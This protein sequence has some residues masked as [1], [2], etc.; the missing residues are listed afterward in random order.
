MASKV[1][2]W[3]RHIR[4]TCFVRIP[5]LSPTRLF[6]SFT[7]SKTHVSSVHRNRPLQSSGTATPK[8]T[9]SKEAKDVFVRDEAPRSV[10]TLLLIGWNLDVPTRQRSTLQ[11]AKVARLLRGRSAASLVI[12][13]NDVTVGTWE[14]QT[15][16]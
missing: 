11:G 2:V 7:P 3:D 16:E 10:A 9:T 8:S 5:T 13:S 6:Q 4:S 12:D 1:L 15:E 14:L